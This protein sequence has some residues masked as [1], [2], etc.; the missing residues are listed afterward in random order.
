MKT[1]VNQ[2]NLDLD[3][4]ITSEEAS[5][6]AVVVA[7]LGWLN[8]LSRNRAAS[9]LILEHKAFTGSR[10]DFQ[11]DVRVLTAATSLLLEYFFAR[12]RLGNRLAISN[13]RLAHIGFNA[14]F[15]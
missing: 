5:L 10:F 2:T 13:L 12:S 7:L 8:K 11:F 15:T 3:Q 9:D 6:P 14:E 4:V 1:A